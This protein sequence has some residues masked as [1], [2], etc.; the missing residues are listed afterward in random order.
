MI[1]D[2]GDIAIKLSRNPLGI[3]AL[4][5]VL[6]Y[7][8]SGYVTSSN[9]LDATNREVLIW[10][11]VGFPVLVLI[12]FYALVTKHHSKIYGPSDFSDD[13]NFMKYIE[14]G[15]IRKDEAIK[16]ETEPKPDRSIIEY[17]ILNTLWTK[18]VNHSPDYSRVW[19]FRVND[20]APMYQHYR[21][22]VSKLFEEGLVRETDN[23]QIYLTPSGYKWCKVNYNQFP[24]DQW[25]PENSIKPENLE[26]VLSSNQS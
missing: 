19:T 1:K 17:K 8:I 24:D 18:Q 7:G 11:L 9:S 15:E 26:K 20:N 12:M 2:F 3:I 6:V 13:E 14:T 25:W 10:F 21:D 4:S 5:L 22:T 16:N 23:G